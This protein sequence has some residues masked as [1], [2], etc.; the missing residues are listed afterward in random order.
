MKYGNLKMSGIFQKTLLVSALIAAPAIGSFALTEIMPGQSVLTAGSASAQSAQPLKPNAEQIKPRRLPG[1][2]QRFVTEM[3]EITALIDPEEDSGKQPEIDRA[4][5]MLNDISRKIDDYNDFE[6]SMIYQIYGQIYFEREDTN[7]MIKSFEQ[8]VAQS[9]NIPPGTEAQYLFILAQLYMQEE[10]YGK[11]IDYIRRWTQLV[12]NITPDQYYTIGQIFYSN[13]DFANAKANILEAIRLYEVDGRIPKEDWLAFMRTIY[14]FEENYGEA[15]DY[16]TQLVVHYPKMTYWTQLASL[17][18]EEGRIDSYYRALDTIYV[19]GGLR[20]ES[21]LKGLAGH[22][23]ESD[24]PYKAAKILDKGL[25]QDKII[26]ATEANLEMLANSWRMAQERSAALKE[27]KR[28]AQAADEGEL[29]YSLGR[30]LFAEGQ[31]DEAAKAIRDA[32]RKGNLRRVDQV[33]I[34]LGQVEVE[35]GN[36]EEAHKAFDV[37]AKD[38][39]SRRLANQWKKFADD[40]KIRAKAL[41]EI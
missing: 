34:T 15:L 41:A 36:F 11:S 37:A 35:R 19:M 28:A 18:Y 6:K 22:F 32:L 14:F 26:A 39:R 23:L 4:L 25:N 16:V 8:I 13:E 20:K 10:Q 31:L 29:Y 12:N 17:Y 21:E 3:Q 2:S 7:N 38:D 27:M 30:L 1:Q 33:Q 5:R 24:A 40:E 9:P